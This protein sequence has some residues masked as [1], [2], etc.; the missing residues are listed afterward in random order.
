M[1]QES[2]VQVFSSLLPPCPD[3]PDIP[4]PS[5][6]LY[7]AQLSEDDPRL[8]LQ[9][10]RAA[11]DILL[12]HLKGKDRAIDVNKTGDE[13]DIK[14][15]IVQALVSQVEIWMDPSYD[16][17]FEPEAESTCE[18]LI[19]LALDTDPGNV[20][21]LQALASVRLSQQRPA[22]A[23]ECLGKAWNN[24]KDLDPDNEKLPCI[25]TRLTTARLFLEL[26]LFEPALQV[27][28]SIMASDDRNVEAWYLE[29]WCFFLMSEEAR[30][31]EG[32]IDALTWQEFGRDARDCLETCKNFH[33]NEGHPDLPLLKHA[34]ELIT[35]LDGLGVSAS[36]L[37]EDEDEESQW[38][39]PQSSDLDIDMG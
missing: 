20:E 2:P 12:T 33:V 3:A 24:W 1:P 4:P 36:I 35:Q 26:H 16:L 38:E 22:D 5:A 31:A 8:A 11:I 29:G 21:A 7:L 10:Y 15:S 14:T 18:N 25:P 28:Q 37:E 32:N 6:H 9:H 19:S 27:L 30:K 17:C 23:K 13:A 34:E 39:S